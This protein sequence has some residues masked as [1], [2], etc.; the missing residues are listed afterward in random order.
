MNGFNDTAGAISSGGAST[1]TIK[2]SAATA[3]VLQ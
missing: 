1:G 3:S 2:N